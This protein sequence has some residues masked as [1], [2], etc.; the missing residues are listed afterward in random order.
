[1]ALAALTREEDRQR[2]L[3][4]GFQEYAARHVSADRLV[5]CVAAAAASGAAEG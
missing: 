2:L 1:V 5:R 4:A 3:A